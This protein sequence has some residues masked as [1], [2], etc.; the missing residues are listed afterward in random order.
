MAEASISSCRFHGQLVLTSFQFPLGASYLTTIQP[1]DNVHPL[2]K[3]LPFTTLPSA[4][5]R[6][7]G[8]ANVLKN[9]SFS[10]SSHP[11][12]LSPP[13][14]ILPYVL[15]PLASGCDSYSES[16]TDQ[17]LEELQFLESDKKREPKSNILVT[18]LETLLLL[19]T[20][21]EGREM[22]REAGCYFVVR[23]LHLA[24]ENEDVRE[25]CDRLVQVL[26]RDEEGEEHSGQ[27]R[28]APVSAL[29]T[30][31]D[32]GSDRGMMVTQADSEDED[33]QIVEIF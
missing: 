29:V 7:L 8:I 31:R 16:E 19:T 2:S 3:L 14:S 5:P 33:E 6:R 1:Y 11:T 30:E 17:M 25:G 23:E 28:G 20:T 9:V 13:L 26:M 10:V 21:R 15:L 27:S 4:L 22:L 18:H 32:G 24:V 12:L